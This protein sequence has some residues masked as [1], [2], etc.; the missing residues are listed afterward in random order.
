MARVSEHPTPRQ[1]SKRRSKGPD[2]ELLQ[3]CAVWRPANDR[4]IEILDQIGSKL[5][6]DWSAEDHALQREVEETNALE[7][8]IFR[9]KARTLAGL[10]AK[11]AVLAHLD[12]Q[13]APAGTAE[14]ASSLAADI[15]SLGGDW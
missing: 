7:Q 10:K 5:E 4:S 14:Y 2:A 6:R 13:F 12:A 1:T 11:A 15:M 3:L 8:R 9:M